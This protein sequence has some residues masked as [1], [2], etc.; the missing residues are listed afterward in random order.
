MT[1][2]GNDRIISEL[3]KSLSGAEARRSERRMF[4]VMRFTASS[5]TR[6]IP[7]KQEVI[8]KRTQMSGTTGFFPLIN[9]SESELGRKEQILLRDYTDVIQRLFKPAR[10]ALT[11][12]TY[13]SGIKTSDFCL[14]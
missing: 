4:S 13:S 3:I 2:N 1:S 6:F 11:S 7:S 9:G 12:L 10:L 8:N 5:W 14:P